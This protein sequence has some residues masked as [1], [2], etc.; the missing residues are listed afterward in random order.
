M[1]AT[2][3]A[4]LSLVVSLVVGIGAWVVA[5]ANV[6]RQLQVA[7]REAWRREFRE[8]VAVLLASDCAR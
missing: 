5:L 3:L 2:I 8:K 1:T 6:Q 4:V 7:A